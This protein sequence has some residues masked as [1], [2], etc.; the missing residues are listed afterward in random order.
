MSTSQS[1]YTNSTHPSQEL[2]D[3]IKSMAK[4]LITQL[5]TA[6]LNSRPVNEKDDPDRPDARKWTIIT[7]HR[8]LGEA[9]DDDLD[10]CIDMRVKNWKATGPQRFDMHVYRD[11]VL[12]RVDALKKEQFTCL[13]GVWGM[14]RDLI[15]I[16]VT[17]TGGDRSP[18]L[19]EE[20]RFR[21][22][23]RISAKFAEKK[24]KRKED[25]DEDE[26]EDKKVGQEVD[27]EKE[28]VVDKEAGEEELGAE[29]GGV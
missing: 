22:D 27:K 4:T 29:E 7:G 25:E 1:R 18:F 20:R 24:R 26:D 8:A 11:S 16:G 5:N 6:N 2:L 13:E 12:P 21:F 14:T 19:R 28:D 17:H 10:V 9:E 3:R 15:E 23:M